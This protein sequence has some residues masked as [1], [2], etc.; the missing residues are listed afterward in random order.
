MGLERIEATWADLRSRADGGWADF[1]A[2]REAAVPLYRDAV[3]AFLSGHAD[4]AEFRSRMDSLSKKENWW[5]FRG[6]SQMFFNQLLKAAEPTELD[7]ALRSALPPPADTAEA[8]EKIADFLHFVDGVRDRAETI[9]ATKPAPGR[10]PAFLS[11]F[12]ELEQRDAWP[13]FYPSSRGVLE[14]EALLSLSDD[15]AENYRRFRAVMHDLRDRLGTDTWTVEH[16]LWELRP[17]AEA[18]EAAADEQ[19]DPGPDAGQEGT[20]PAADVYAAYRAQGL[21]FPDD[22]VTSFVLSL[23][24]K[25]F[26]I[27]SGISGTGKTQIALGL[28]RHLESIGSG[29]L[30]EIAAPTDGPEDIFIKLNSGVLERMRKTLRATARE[31]VPRPERGSSISFDRVHLDGGGTGSMR[32]NNINFTDESKEA[33]ILFFRKDMADWIRANARVDD[34]LRIHIPHDGGDPHASIVPQVVEESGE[35]VRRHLLVPVRSEWTDPRGLLGYFNPLSE[36]YVRTDLL[37]LILKAITDPRQ[38]YMVI[39][40]EMNL[41]RVEYY[42]SD[43]LSAIESGEAIPL[44]P[45]SADDADADEEIPRKLALP[46]NLSIVGTVN[47]DETTHAFS[48]KVL[49]RA[50]VI[51]FSDVDLDRA[52]GEVSP[53]A[54]SAFRVEAGRLQPSWFVRRPEVAA[55]RQKDAHAYSTFTE[56]LADVHTILA[57]F[58]RHFGY[59]V[60]DEISRYV[61][62]ALQKVDGDADEIVRVAFDLQLCQKVLPKL[63]GGRELEEPLVHLLRFCMDGT[64]HPVLDA[65]EVV[66]E[67]RVALAPS[68]SVGHADIRYAR[69]AKKLLRML[70]RL[71]ATGFVSALE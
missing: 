11:F 15:F 27:L 14:T 5:G 60:V 50:N 36:E 18:E 31:V 13:I 66:D 34:Y 37:E 7:R 4:A 67:A 65:D 45:G 41:A 71:R 28:A 3:V 40:D 16:V 2:K 42:L 55:A 9:G 12:W 70:D 39:L 51:E 52:L 19:P 43:F 46:S 29:G 58:D 62:H 22:V 56:P 69:A 68:P 26:V 1:D 63:T 10:V 23:A 59:R 49:D 47:V 6:N 48:P 8:D 20:Q 44:L 38:P 54:V 21:H 61:G 57:R 35:A 30:V 32:L 33:L 17:G 25:G 53:A 64:T 24:T